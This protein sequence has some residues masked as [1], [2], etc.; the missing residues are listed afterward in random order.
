MVLFCCWLFG[1]LALASCTLPAQLLPATA[2]PVAGTAQME[3][4]V[5][6]DALLTE[7]TFAEQGETFLDQ[8]ARAVQSA[9]APVE[10]RYISLPGADEIL[11]QG[12]WITFS[13]RSLIFLQAANTGGTHGVQIQFTPPMTSSAAAVAGLAEL[14]L[15]E[16]PPKVNTIVQPTIEFVRARLTGRE[17]E[18]EQWAFDVT[19]RYPDRGWD[20]Y[21][22]GWQVETPDAAILGTRILLHP[23]VDEQ[24]FT[25]TL[26]NVVVP[27]GVK[28]V[29]LRAHTLVGGYTPAAVEIP[30]S[31]ARSTD[32]YVVER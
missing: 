28:T 11:W 18:A 8:I 31:I 20:D 30:L 27:R 3:R 14:A 16:P 15:P 23:H 1:L 32:R 12:E 4:A 5:I 29:R 26:S 6:A 19:L 7:L 25:R 10:H 9:G 13:D 2:T 21:A 24:P 17:G 22:D